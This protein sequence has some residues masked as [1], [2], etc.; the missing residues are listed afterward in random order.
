MSG[1]MNSNF[2]G[3]SKKQ[4]YLKNPFDYRN[5]NSSENIK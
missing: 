3:S 5:G 4:Q 2:S 1:V